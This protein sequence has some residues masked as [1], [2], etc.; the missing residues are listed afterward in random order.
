[1][2]VFGTC[3]TENQWNFVLIKETWRYV[4]HVME[5]N[6]AKVTTKI[7][8]KILLFPLGFGHFQYMGEQKSRPSLY[9]H[10]NKN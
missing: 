7:E 3:M 1:M 8:R 2:I 10:G 4:N 9:L 6:C 5:R